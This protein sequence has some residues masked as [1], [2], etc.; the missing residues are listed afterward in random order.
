MTRLRRIALAGVVAIV[1]A[2]SFVVVTPATYAVV[3]VGCV[4][5]AL[6]IGVAA[7]LAGELTVHVDEDEALEEVFAGMRELRRAV[8]SAGLLIVGASVTAILVATLAVDHDDG[9]LGGVG[10]TMYRFYAL[11]LGILF[12]VL[13]LPAVWT[14]TRGFRIGLSVWLGAGIVCA[15]VAAA[16]DGAVAQVGSAV[17]LGAPS[18]AGVAV[19]LVCAMANGPRAKLAIVLLIVWGAVYGAYSGA[20]MA[21]DAELWW[22]MPVGAVMQ[23][24]IMLVA[25]FVVR[26]AV[27]V[28]R[29]WRRRPRTRLTTSVCEVCGRRPAQVVTLRRYVGML[30]TYRSYR[31]EGP[32]CKVHATDRASEWFG[33]TVAQG[34]WEPL[35]FYRNLN[36]V[37]IDLAALMQASKMAPP[38]GPAA[39][40]V[41][42][43]GSSTG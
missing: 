10:S 14:R 39:K 3:L 34:W 43:P 6:V 31:F 8:G 33:R 20:A 1:V 11:A 27:G 7:H 42:A 12:L 29:R 26:A 32:L 19:A 18:I 30:V 13:L 9:G 40:P 37:R 38:Q 35:T 23:P 4:F 41:E 36:A 15:V 21:T 28:A 25:V 17:L 22:S 16:V 24:A 5:I 2:A